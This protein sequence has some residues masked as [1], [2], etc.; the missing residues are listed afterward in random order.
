MVVTLCRHL[1][2]HPH[3]PLLPAS[4]RAGLARPRPASGQADHG[5]RA[6]NTVSRLAQYAIGE[7]L[8]ISEHVIAVTVVPEDAMKHRPGPRA[9]A[10]V[11]PL[12][13]ACPCTLNTEYVGGGAAGGVHRPLCA[14]HDKQIVVLIPVVLPGYCVTSSRTTYDLVCPP[15]CAAPDVVAPGSRCPGVPMARTPPLPVT[16]MPRAGRPRVV[17]LTRTDDRTLGSAGPRNGADHGRDRRA[18]AA[19]QPSP[20]HRWGRHAAAATP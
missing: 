11:G 12:N 15:R 1:P 4:C 14:Q 8:S 17:L 20:G 9:G 16:G 13:S 5:D 18:A 6:G 2:V 3:P 19:G 7:A 10:A